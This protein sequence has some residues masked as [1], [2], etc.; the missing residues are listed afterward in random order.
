MTALDDGVQAT[1]TCKEIGINIEMS[2]Q[3]DTGSEEGMD[4]TE[5]TN[6]EDAQPTKPTE[7]T[8]T[9]TEGTDDTETESVDA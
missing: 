6:D 3:G 1:F 4:D 2:S 5:P 7:T 8:N 9:T